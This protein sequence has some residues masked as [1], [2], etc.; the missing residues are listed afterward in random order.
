MKVAAEAAPEQA[1][2][3]KVKLNRVIIDKV[4]FVI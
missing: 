3:A 2:A 1:R 4:L